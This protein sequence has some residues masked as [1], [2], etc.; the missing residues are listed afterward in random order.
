MDQV[1][2]AT[3]V[4]STMNR[5]DQIDVVLNQAAAVIVSNYLQHL[6]TV[7]EKA[8]INA[9]LLPFDNQQVLSP[10]ELVD[11]IDKVQ[12]ALRTFP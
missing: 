9:G 7:I 10:T 3:P 6:N 2:F 1:T 11:L 8:G 4:S 5:A 12:G